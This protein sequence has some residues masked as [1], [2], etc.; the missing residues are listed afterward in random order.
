M[1]QTIIAIIA[2]LALIALWI[3]STQRKLVVLDENIGNAMIQIGVQL[4]CR[5]D[6]L[7]ALLD[8][9]KG[10]AKH[11]SETLIE[12]IK[13]RRS[14]I[15]AKSTPDDVVHQEGLIS[16]A[17]SRIAM[18][19][20]QYPELKENQNYI[21]TMNAEE[22]FENMV[23]TSCLIYNDSVTKLNREIRMFPVFMIAGILGFRQRD[24]LEEK[25]H[26]PGCRWRSQKAE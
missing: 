13:L 2:T 18:L 20:E 5:F 16:E 23:R 19:T 11:E 9:T 7:T 12:T 17:L 22:I 26:A 6:A 25:A 1:L 21:K 15:T 3:I 14:I 24:Y 10:Y 8:L 4:S